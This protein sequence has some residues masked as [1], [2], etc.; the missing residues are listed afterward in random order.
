MM[1]DRAYRQ[2]LEADLARWQADGVIAPEAIAAIRVVLPPIPAGVNIAAVV[3]IVGGLLIAAA[4]LAF[5]AAHWTELARAFRL[6]LLF[7]G[8]VSASGLGAWC[9]HSGRPV[10]ADLCASVAAIIFG[11]GIALVGQMYHL[12]GDFAG[13]MLLWS[14]GALASA[15]LT[16]SRGAL[17]V[18][19]AAA[20]TW[21]AMNA[22]EA[23][24]VLHIPF[25][26]FWL[27][28]ACLAIAWSSRV[29][30]HLVAVATL[31]WWFSATLES[32]GSEPLFVLANGAALLFGSGLAL[33]EASSPRISAFGRVLSSYGAF[34][35]A[36]CLAAGVSFELFRMTGGGVSQPPWAIACGVAGVI[37]ATVAAAMTRRAGPIYAAGA[38]GL[39]LFAILTLTARQ[40]GEPWLTYAIELAAVLCL[41]VSGVLDGARP[42]I[43]AGWL[44]IAG[45]IAGIT[46]ALKGSLLYSSAFLAVAG[47]IAVLLAIAL[48]RVLPRS[49]E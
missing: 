17:A 48:N 15:A 27:A 2:R 8:I 43:A 6:A 16:G 9:A 39:F 30:A 37:S 24:D 31:P 49:D 7:A 10:L 19:L 13:G 34:L 26:V 38:L 25:V 4:F 41:V 42:R 23:R 5:V 21:T 33:G 32:G 1:F 28:A 12:G 36:G 22:F 29:A 47:A 18:A 46:W 45:V 35:L 14:I 44:G 20:S 11:A 40:S 3:A